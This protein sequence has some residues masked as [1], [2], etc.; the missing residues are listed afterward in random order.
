ME[1]NS[2]KIVSVIPARGGSKSIP[3]KNIRLLN[4]IPLVAYSIKYSISCPIINNTVVS[5][6]SIEIANISKK[7]GAEIPFIR[8][9]ELALDDT[10]DYPVMHHALETLEKL[11][12]E[13][14]KAIV[15]LRPTS[16]LR[17]NGLIEKG[18]E[19][20][21]SLPDVTSV[22]SVALSKEHPYRQWQ[23]N[24]NYIYGYEDGVNEPYNIPRQKLP[25]IYFQTGDIEIILRKTLL[26]GS[27]SGNKIAPLIIDHDQ[28]LDIDN[29]V[30]LQIAES[31]LSK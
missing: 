14:I 7:Y 6:D 30:D 10:T 15:L 9:P 20:I 17:P 19:I 1:K 28:I 26:N 29:K 12:G 23:L 13:K 4:G 3:Q 8:P 24:D 27:V 21:K 22:R 2:L 11:Y 16:P 25:K 18:F 31:K 5:T